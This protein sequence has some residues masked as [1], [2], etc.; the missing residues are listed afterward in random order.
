MKGGLTLKVLEFLSDAVFTTVQLS[1]FFLTDY[2]T[3]YRRLRGLPEYRLKSKK[4][5]PNY[6]ENINKQ[7]L[8][9]LLYRL[10]KDGFIQKTKSGV[11]K[12]TKKGI[13]KK[14]LLKSRK[15]L[16]ATNYQS[17]AALEW[18]IVIFDIPERDKRKRVWIR[19][20]LK[21]IGFKMLQ[22]SVWIGK[23]ALPEKF[24]E[25]LSRMGLLSYVEILAITK[26]G[27]LKHLE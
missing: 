23:V 24:I 26:S 17:K 21:R 25:D 22:R 14:S 27:S 4:Y 20:A 5:D 19:F 12:I 16:P 11:W 6:I 18:K 9:D 15:A 7:R 10:R 13:S 1:E 8:Y 3:S 2:V